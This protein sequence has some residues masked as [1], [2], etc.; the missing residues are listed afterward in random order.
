MPPTIKNIYPTAD[1]SSQQ[2]PDEVVSNV[3]GKTFVHDAPDTDANP[4]LADKVKLPVQLLSAMNV[5]T[6]TLRN[7]HRKIGKNKYY[8]GDDDRSAACKKLETFIDGTKDFTGFDLTTM[9]RKVLK[10]IFKLLDVRPDSKERAGITLKSIRELYPVIL[11]KRIFK[12]RGRQQYADY[13]GHECQAV[14]RALESLAKK[15]HEYFAL[16]EEQRQNKMPVYRMLF[17][18]NTIIEIIYSKDNLNKNEVDGMTPKKIKAT[19]NMLIRLTRPE[20]LANISKY[21]RLTPVDYLKE[22]RLIN[23]D[24]IKMPVMLDAFLDWLHL[25]P[26]LT[27]RRNRMLLFEAFHHYASYLKNRKRNNNS[28]INCYELAKKMG[29][30]ASYQL[31]QPGKDGPVDVFN[32][33]PKKYYHHNQRKRNVAQRLK[34]QKRLGSGCPP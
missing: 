3:Q 12:S 16:I 4:E 21:F 13:C 33:N 32:L 14:D 11:D 1:K 22:V 8:G 10:G 34:N 15:K 18:E 27:I 9:E 2:T 29:Y 26:E 25:A 24:I 20:F 23:P 7:Y 6:A 17:T 19:G 5:T 30:L 31:D 28:L